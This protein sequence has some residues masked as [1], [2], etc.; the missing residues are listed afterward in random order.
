MSVEQ[1]QANY[2]TQSLSE[3]Y[4]HVRAMQWT[5]YER[6]KRSL[7]KDLSLLLRPLLL[8]TIPAVLLARGA[9]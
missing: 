9:Y 3:S 7:R 1:Q 4:Q 2:R 8:R 5:M 6:V